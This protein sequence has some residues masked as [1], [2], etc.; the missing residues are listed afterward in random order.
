MKTETK[1]LR[2]QRF[3]NVTTVRTQRLFPLRGFHRL[4]EQFR[5]NSAK[6]DLKIIISLPEFRLLQRI[7]STRELV[8]LIP[9]H[10]KTK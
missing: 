6:S 4:L 10:T 8:L 9:K 2:P 1:Q 7:L 3:L 5:L